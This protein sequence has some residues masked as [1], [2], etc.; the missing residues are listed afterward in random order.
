MRRSDLVADCG[1]CAAGRC[2]ALP[3]DA[4][5]D[6]AFHKESGVACR[7][8]DGTTS[9]IHVELVDRGFLG[10]AVY[11]CYGAGPR[12]TRDGGYASSVSTRP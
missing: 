7:H 2:I 10:C 12:A 3:F 5:E 6:F 8:L 1:A 9:T 4:S 11:D